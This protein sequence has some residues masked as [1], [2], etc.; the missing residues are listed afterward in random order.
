M[1]FA[2]RCV[3]LVVLGTVLSSCA[4]TASTGDTLAAPAHRDGPHDFDFHVGTWH[5][6][7]SR[8]L[9]PLTG[10]STWVEYEGTT[11]VRPVWN[12][13]AN[14]VELTAHGPAGDLEL[15]SL[16]L[17]D[18]AARQ[19][20]LHVASAADGSMSPPT[21]G[22]FDNGRG[23]FFSR[24]TIAN[25]P[26]L[27]RFVIS[28]I[29]PSSCHFEQAFSIDGGTTWEVNWIATD[30]RTLDGASPSPAGGDGAS[31]ALSRG[32]HRAGAYAAEAE[33][34]PVAP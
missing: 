2:S 27:V 31:K 5:T 25:R 15:L 11:V 33:H 23:E 28:D 20:A 17:Y 7:I 13:R 24:E 3:I 4:T 10:S 18:P 8:R 26:T 30:T 21:I 29:T 9:H 19:W 16:R 1:L 14:L 12:G 22:H 32:S 34:E 6:K